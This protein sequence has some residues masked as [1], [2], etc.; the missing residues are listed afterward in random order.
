MNTFKILFIATT[1]F[2]A[3]SS[4]PMANAT[5][6]TVV[7]DSY[8]ATSREF[9]DKAAAANRKVA[10]HERM[11]RTGG[12]PKSSGLG[13][14]KHCERLIAQYQADAAE[15]VAKAAEYQRLAGTE[16]AALTPDQHLTIARD[17]DAKAAVAN[18][19]V[20]A[21]KAMA[22]H[23]VSPKYGA[24]VLRSHC[25]GLVLQYRA[26]ADSYAVQAAEHQRLAATK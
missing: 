4:A 10:V 12:S 17:L 19:K 16:A 14:A 24:R 26:A 25:E 21:H 8:L 23:R 22:R 11:A 5:T 7:V 6:S 1:A 2:V 13:M 9:Q 20:A 18:A 15:Y 3:I